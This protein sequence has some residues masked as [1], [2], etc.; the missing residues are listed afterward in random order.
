GGG[1]DHGAG[2]DVGAV[3]AGG[4]DDVRHAGNLSLGDLDGLGERELADPLTGERGDRVGQRWR[5]RG[6]A[7]LAHSGWRLSGLDQ[8]DL[9]LWNRAHSHHR[10]GVEVPGD[11]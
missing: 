10:I 6:D 2:D 8:V 1:E 11:D 9:D 7:D 5:D 4:D 3:F